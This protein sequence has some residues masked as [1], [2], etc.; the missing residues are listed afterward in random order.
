MI[1]YKD[2]KGRVALIVVVVGLLL[3]GWFANGIRFGQDLVGGTTLRFALDIEGAKRAGRISEDR[4]PQEV[5]TETIAVIQDRVDRTGLGET[6][7]L[8]LGQDRFQISLPTTSE[9]QAESVIGVVTQLGDLKFRIEVLPNEYY[10][11]ERAE[12]PRLATENVW[13]QGDVESFNAFKRQEIERWRAARVAGLPYEPS[14]KRFF[15]AKAKGTDGQ[16]ES[17][18][19]VLEE[20]LDPTER[21]FGGAIVVNPAKAINHDSR[22][23]VVT[24]DIRTEWQNLFGQW[25]GRNRLLPM[26]IVLN[27][28]Y[29]SAPTIRNALTTN[30]EVSLGAGSFAQLE[31]EAEQ[32][33]TVLQT[34]SLKIQPRL[35]SENRIGA[36]LAGESRDR[37]LI[38]IVAAFLLVL[39]FMLVYYRVG[40]LV[41]NVALL[42]NVV[43]L[44]GFMAIFKAVLTLP[45][46]A[47]IVLTIGMA[48]D[49]N[50]LINER[51]RDEL[52]AGRGLHRALSEGYDRALSAILDGNLTS[53]IVAIFLYMFGSGPI[54]GFA[55]TMLI[56]LFVSL[57]TAI[58]VTRTIFEW[59]LHKGWIKKLSIWGSGEPLSIDWIGMRRIL[60]PVTV[61]AMLFGFVQFLTSDKYTLYDVD[62]TGGYRATAAFG[63]PASVDDVKGALSERRTVTVTR[64]TFD[65]N[66]T[67]QETPLQVEMGPFDGAE[68]VAVG[69]ERRAADIKVQRL[70][71][72]ATEASDL[73]D[74]ERASAFQAFLSAALEERLL[75]RWVQRGPD[76]YHH[77]AGGAAD[78]PL[79]DQDGGV[80]LRVALLDPKG[81]LTAEHLER[82]LEQDFPHW[83]EE[84][85]RQ[86]PKSPTAVSIQR[87]VVVRD[88]DSPAAGTKAFDVWI[89]TA[90]STGQTL[91]ISPED[92][93]H[94]LGEY[95]GGE[96]F[97]AGLTTRVGSA[98]SPADLEA[99]QPSQPF[100]STDV[101]GS[102]VA[103]RLKDDAI[104]ALAFSLLGIIV[105]VAFRFHSKAMG[106]AAVL[107]LVHDVVVVLGLTAISNQLGFV[108]AKIS[109]VTVAAFL[110][111][112][113]YSVNDTVVIFDRVR[114]N[115]GKRPDITKD[116]LNLSI[117]QTL[118]R[119]I[120][121]AVTFL[122]VCL[123]LFVI[124]YGQRNVLEGFSW[125]LILG[126][127]IGA[128]STVAIGC[129]LLLYLPW[130]WKRIGGFAPRATIVTKPLSNA[131]TLIL[132]PVTALVYAAWWL[133]FGVAA[134]VI[135]LA[136]FV[137]WALSSDADTAAVVSA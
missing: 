113:G 41:A 89:R 25:T 82:L 118:A 32:L 7:I 30:V 6:Q 92:W 66:D 75:P 68:V 24:Y 44:I 133:V 78:D 63:V 37:G 131:L 90:S 51:I 100:P 64:R 77:P 80:S 87:H 43:L 93:R 49:A 14:D 47:G 117:N 126:S 45:G 54:R 10:S 106:F 42:L 83:V 129:T 116:L 99:I 88:V 26:A 120:K 69:S 8:P 128:F 84:D 62:F 108:D 70:F 3:W 112:V 23:P 104:K 85:G 18:F 94:R 56:G 28:E 127:V 132:V 9:G 96:R 91:P 11:G 111:L 101:I 121:T 79:K 103:K 27:D 38:A 74:E 107:C 105:Y 119:S 57:F 71:D 95:L 21:Q 5:V 81:L 29:I 46:I 137:P 34:G 53:I 1:E 134:F 55:I 125:V 98:A 60:V 123:A 33:V 136:M 67:P 2:L 114:E 76:V 73:S 86:V 13:P 52:R 102:S 124:N 135:G 31:K 72:E 12:A 122:L 19:H 109:L 20:P 65:E 58:Y 39:V 22:Q 115:R 61:F 48:V 110:T 35:E 36:S 4:D 40:G 59:A 17:H 50:I 97:L 16:S 130:L 15:L